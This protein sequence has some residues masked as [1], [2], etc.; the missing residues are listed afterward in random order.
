MGGRGRRFG[1]VI[2]L[3]GADAPHR[4]CDLDGRGGDG[5]EVVQAAFTLLLVEAPQVAFRTNRHGRH[6]PEG[7]AEMGCHR[8]LALRRSSQTKSH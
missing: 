6:H 2:A 3:I 5:R 7:A 8:H 4:T 1:Q